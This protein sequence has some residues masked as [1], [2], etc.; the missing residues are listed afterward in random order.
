VIKESQVTPR[1]C[2]HF[3]LHTEAALLLALSFTIML[4]V[5]SACRAGQTA[6]ETGRP[7]QKTFSTPKEA[8]DALIQAA[9]VFDVI[10]LRQVL[11]PS[12]EH[13][14]TSKD[15][16][17]DKNLAAAF[18]AK[19]H[20]KNSIAVDPKNTSRGILVVGNQEWPFP[21]PIVMR[22]GKW[23][24]DTKAGIQE[25]LFRRIGSNELDAIQ[26]CR[27]Y[28]EAQHEYALRKHD[29]SQVN[30]YAQ[31][32]LSTP[33]K[34]DGL[35]WRNPDGSLGGPIAE[36]IA[37]ALEQGYSDR[38]QP[39]H[40]YYFK[41]LKG[42]GPSAPLGRLDFVVNGAM[43]GGF[44]LAA[45]PANYRVTGVKSFIVSYQGIVYEKDLGPDTLRIFHDMTLF[46]PDKTW[47]PTNDNWPADVAQTSVSNGGR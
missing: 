20:Q 47:K 12:V 27:G 17:Q 15:P 3:G 18:A 34:H 33:G 9:E 21:I 11:G 22:N 40:G 36:P 1:I 32:I 43:I 38:S 25:I 4:I 44:A 28:V 14:I 37:K 13:L 23:L 24:F 41:I 29:A 45:A 8:A 10:T 6:A 19:A 39:Y 31:R 7:I 30:Q 5:P 46:D 35:V 26:I 16:V 42:Q 2:N